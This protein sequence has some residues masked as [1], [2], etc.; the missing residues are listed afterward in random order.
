VANG[1][2]LNNSYFPR[3][4]YDDNP[5][6]SDDDKRREYKLGPKARAPSIRDTAARE[7]NALSGDADWITFDA[8]VST[9]PIRSRLRRDTSSTTRSKMAVECFVYHMDVPIL[10]FYSIQSLAMR[11]AMT[12]QGVAIDVYYHPGT[13]TTSIA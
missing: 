6:L 9:A 10:N 12:L 11:C 2:F 5:E 7:N 1:T 3:L 4:G 8:D 13:N